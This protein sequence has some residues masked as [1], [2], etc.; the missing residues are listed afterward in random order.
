M[1]CIGA[2]RPRRWREAARSRL[3]ERFQ[4]CAWPHHTAVNGTVTPPLHP[5]TYLQSYA[6]GK[7]W[8]FKLNESRINYF[9]TYCET[10]QNSY[11]P[12]RTCSSSHA[13]LDTLSS[14]SLPSPP[15][16]SRLIDNGFDVLE[17]VDGG[18]MTITPPH[19]NGIVALRLDR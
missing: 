18:L 6:R 7:K 17:G 14:P 19:S 11:H 10:L 13:K 15:L 16:P 12:S 5:S 1:W 4:T 9:N 2:T 3:Y 8:R